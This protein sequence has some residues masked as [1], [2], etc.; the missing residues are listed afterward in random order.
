M[1]LNRWGSVAPRA[2]FRGLRRQTPG[3]FFPPFNIFF[4]T[5]I[6]PSSEES[7][8]SSSFPQ[9]E[10]DSDIVVLVLRQPPRPS[11]DRGGASTTSTCHP[12]VGG[13]T[14]LPSGEP[15]RPRSDGPFDFDLDLD[16]DIDQ[17]SCPR[18][19]W[20]PSIPLSC[21]GLVF[22]RH[23]AP[24][25]DSTRPR[26][27]TAPVTQPALPF[28]GALRPASR[29]PCLVCFEA[30]LLSFIVVAKLLEFRGGRGGASS[31]FGC[32]AAGAGGIPFRV[33]GC[34]SSARD[35]DSATDAI[36][37]RDLDLDLVRLIDHARQPIDDGTITPTKPL[38][39]TSASTVTKGL[40]KRGEADEGAWGVRHPLRA[41]YFCTSAAPAHPSTAPPSPMVE[42]DPAGCVYGGMIARDGAMVVVVMKK[43]VTS[44]SEQDED[45][46]AKVLE[47]RFTRRKSKRDNRDKRDNRQR[48]CRKHCS[49][50]NSKG[51]RGDK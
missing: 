13:D 50:M 45:V 37:D 12:L 25:L 30:K 31:S 19:G 42:G 16:I 11:S 23:L 40:M 20:N 8:R 51:R 28:H 21:T 22:G 38:S 32:V 4:S 44:G 24:R 9:D 43:E 34:D 18:L 48:R 26:S 49:E 36:I 15:T 10:L 1:T 6:P 46:G 33:L 29:G 7:L 14:P 47:V 27:L 2:R 17:L 3:T 35:L 39:P 5:C 41:G